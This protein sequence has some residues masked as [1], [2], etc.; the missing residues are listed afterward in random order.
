MTALTG[1]RR[2]PR[3]PDPTH[4]HRRLEKHPRTVDPN[5]E[6]NDIGRSITPQPRTEAENIIS[7]RSGQH[8][9]LGKIENRTRAKYTV[10]QG[11]TITQWSGLDTGPRKAVMVD[12]PDEFGLSFCRSPRGATRLQ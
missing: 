9:S 11:H 7:N 2:C 6:P 10:A 5:A 4:L 8:V 12:G 3:L 1:W